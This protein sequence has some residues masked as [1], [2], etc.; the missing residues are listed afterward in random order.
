[1]QRRETK[2]IAKTARKQVSSKIP[3]QLDSPVT[4]SK[5]KVEQPKPAACPAHLSNC[6]RD[7]TRDPI[8]YC[9]CESLAAKCLNLSI[10]LSDHEV[11][12]SLG[13]CFL[14][15]PTRSKNSRVAAPRRWI[16]V[17]APGTLS[18]SARLWQAKRQETYYNKQ[19]DHTDSA[20]MR[21]HR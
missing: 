1:M 21:Q 5:Q 17:I 9:N 15:K 7:Y 14:K 20:R 6:V 18:A 10:R 12:F 19:H 8:A 4:Q 11:F 16:P 3:A 13:L 2:H